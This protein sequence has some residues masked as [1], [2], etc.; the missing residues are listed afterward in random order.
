MERTDGGNRRN[1][2]AIQAAR[3]GPRKETTSRS[4][5]VENIFRTQNGLHEKNSPLSPSKPVPLKRKEVT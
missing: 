5:A 4:A 1:V 2:V 3:V